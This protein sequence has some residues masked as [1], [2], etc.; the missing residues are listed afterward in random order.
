MDETT[1]AR[2]GGEEGEFG[3]EDA[4][5]EDRLASAH[6]RFQDLERVR[7]KHSR[8][9]PVFAV[10]IAVLAVAAVVWMLFFWPDDTTGSTQP[11]VTTTTVEAAA[12]DSSVGQVRAV[13]D[14]LG[15][16]NVAFEQR[17]GTIFLVGIIGS[18]EGRAAIIRTT[19]A[20]VGDTP[21]DAS[22][23]RSQRAAMT[24]DW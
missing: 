2:A 21:L 17:S 4:E 3:E 23:S 16:D 12:A 8:S 5:E 24:F 11:A 6:A 13:L 7:P 14:G 22:G 18:E 9:F 20:L 15:Y 1:S 19:N 10:L